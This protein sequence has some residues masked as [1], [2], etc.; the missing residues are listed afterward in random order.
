VEEFLERLRQ[1]NLV[2]WALAYIAAAFALIRILDVEAQRF[3]R[4]RA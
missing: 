3:G 1:R 2:Q 4:P